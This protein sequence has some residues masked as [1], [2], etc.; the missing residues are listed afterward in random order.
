M[1]RKWKNPK[2]IRAMRRA[3]KK[4]RGK[5]RLDQLTPSGGK[6]GNFIGAQTE[7]KVARVLEQMVE[8]GFLDSYIRYPPSTPEKDFQMRRNGTTLE[9]NITCSA[10]NW[11]K[12]Y[13]RFHNRVKIVYIQVE[14]SD[15]EVFSTLYQL[16]A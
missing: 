11:K 15:H 14:A 12:H 8:A 1:G 2:S 3:R 4:Y 16:I 9:I 10:K 6:Y 5:R 7:D 13:S